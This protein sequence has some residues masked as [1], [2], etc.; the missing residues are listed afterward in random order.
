[1]AVT[2]TQAA[3]KHVRSSMAKRG[4]GEGLRVAVKPTGCSG[5]MYVVDFAD[6]VGPQDQVFESCGLK[7]SFDT[8]LSHVEPNRWVPYTSENDQNCNIGHI[9]HPP[10]R[11]NM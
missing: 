6:E 5:F 3:A 2:L 4:H 7:E 11:L 10:I 8:I 9:G 1:M